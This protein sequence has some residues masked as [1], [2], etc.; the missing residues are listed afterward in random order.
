VLS[1]GGGNPRMHIDGGGIA[2]FYRPTTTTNADVFQLKSNVGGTKNDKFYVEADGDTFN[3]TGS[4]GTIS[5]ER[6]KENIVDANSQWDDIKTLQV[7][8]Y[9]LIADE[10]DSANQIGVIAQELETAGMTGL[11]TEREDGTK[12]VKYSILYMKA[13]KALQEAMDRIETLEAK[14][15]TLEAN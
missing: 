15:A 9:S 14:V 7:R 1:D 12:Q 6:L 3:A 2:S 4:Y 13:V 10:L 8:K 11:V 5:D